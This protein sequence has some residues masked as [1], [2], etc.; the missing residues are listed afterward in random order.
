MKTLGDAPTARLT[1]N[2]NSNHYGIC[3]RV[4]LCLTCGLGMRGIISLN[5]YRTDSTL[6]SVD[7]GHIVQRLHP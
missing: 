2:V 3:Q 6:G 1:V 5:L 7:I 4:R